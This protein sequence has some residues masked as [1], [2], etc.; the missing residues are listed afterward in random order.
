MRVKK[1]GIGRALELVSG[2][3][4]I[5]IGGDREILERVEILEFVITEAPSRLRRL[6]SVL[7]L[8]KVLGQRR[9]TGTTPA[10]A[11]KTLKTKFKIKRIPTQATGA[12]S[13]EAIETQ[14]STTAFKAALL[15]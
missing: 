8:F 10:A 5:F 13:S 4:T 11:A 9:L 7:S 6:L 14:L 2:S 12:A 1:L 15:L 3:E